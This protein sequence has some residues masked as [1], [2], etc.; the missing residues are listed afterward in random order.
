[1][2]FS[3]T[4]S[5]YAVQLSNQLVKFMVQYLIIKLAKQ[6]IIHML[7]HHHA[8]PLGIPLSVL[9]DSKQQQHTK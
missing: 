1:M 2:V 8:L 5:N 3:S 6:D 7:P 4:C 9:L